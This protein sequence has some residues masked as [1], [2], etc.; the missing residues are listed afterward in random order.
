MKTKPAWHRATV[1]YP[2]NEN[3]RSPADAGTVS[4]KTIRDTTRILLL[5]GGSLKPVREWDD[6]GPWSNRVSSLTAENIE[7]LESEF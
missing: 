1:L 5:E 7:W 6:Q 3:P 2:D 4:H